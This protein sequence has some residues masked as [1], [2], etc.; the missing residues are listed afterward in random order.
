MR[1][2][3]VISYLF[4]LQYFSP[5]VQARTWHIHPD[6]AGDAPTIQAGIDSAASADTILVA[7]GIYM[8]EGNRNI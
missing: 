7:I 4:L 6:L 2:P 5:T 3:A 8:G 1:I